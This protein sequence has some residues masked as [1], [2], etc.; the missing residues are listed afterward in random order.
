M[1]LA[2]N[3]NGAI[4]RVECLGFLAMNSSAGYPKAFMLA[5]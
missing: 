3:V 2:G 1:M 4:A 5:G